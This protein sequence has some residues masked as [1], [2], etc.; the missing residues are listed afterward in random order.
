MALTS[1]PNS[2]PL[3]LRLPSDPMGPKALTSINSRPLVS[4]ACLL[5]TNSKTGIG[6]PPLPRVGPPRVGG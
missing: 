6:R 4:L 2:S 5:G 3:V 1:K